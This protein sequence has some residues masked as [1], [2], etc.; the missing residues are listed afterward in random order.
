MIARFHI[1]LPFDLF[2]TDEEQIGM[3]GEISSTAIPNARLVIPTAWGFAER[4]N[5]TG[6]FHEVMFDWL[7]NIKEPALVKVAFTTTSE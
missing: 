1:L 5:P 7:S 2:I 3:Q 6:T 4:P